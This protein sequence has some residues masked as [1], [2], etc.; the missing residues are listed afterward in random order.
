MTEAARRIILE[1]EEDIAIMTIR[2]T[3]S[4]N[5]INDEAVEQIYE[6]CRAI[7]KRVSIRVLVITGDGEKTFSAGG[8]IKAWGALTPQQFGRDWIRRGHDAFDAVARLRVPVI[9]VLNG[10]TFGGGLELAAAA[11]L[12]IA[13]EHVKFGLPEAGL[14][15]IPGWSGTQRAVRRFGPAIVRRMAI[16]GEVLN[17]EQALTSGLIEL[18]VSKGEGLS[19]ARE[20]A[21]TVRARAPLATEIVKMLINVAEEE[22][23]ARVLDAIAGM[24]VASTDDLAEGVAAFKERRRPDF[25]GS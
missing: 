20:I 16:F 18:L 2:H 10:H 19:K 12:R 9:A 4:L 11:D 25:R 23:G 13:E 8:D 6:A 14:G 17:A 24:C 21:A 15:V 3:E 5:A 1:F 7:E 22:E